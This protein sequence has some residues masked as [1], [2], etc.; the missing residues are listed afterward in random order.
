L[1]DLD[2][3]ATNDNDRGLDPPKIAVEFDTRADNTAGDPP[4]DYC[5][6][7]I[8]ANTDTR[9]D[10]LSGDEDAVQYVF[11]GRENFLNIP[12]R[13][14]PPPP[15]P[16]DISN[17]L[18]DDN[19]HDADGEEPTEEWRFGT[20]GPV[21]IWR[22]GIGPDGTI[23]ISDQ[24]D[25]LYALNEDGSTKWTFNL[26]DG[27]DYMPGVDPVTGTIYSDI[28]G[29]S[30]VSI[31]PDGTENWRFLI[32]PGSDVESTP[33]VGADSV[34]YFG[35]KQAQALIALNP[36]GTEKW[37]FPV[38]DEVNNVPALSPDGLTKV[39]FVSNDNF[40]YA[41]NTV[42][43]LA[44]PTG[45][46]GLKPLQGE[47]RFPIPTES[48]EIQSSPTVKQSDGTIYVGADDNYLYAL[49][50]VARQ[51]DPTGV[52]GVNVAQGEWRF[53]TNGEIESSA[54]LDD[55]G[56]IY[57]GSDD[58]NLWAVNPD[59]TEKWRFATGG[60][61]ESSPIVDLDGTI[62]VGSGDNRVYAINPDGSQKWFFVTGGEVPS[63]PVL[64]QAGFIH[65]GSNDTNFYTIS[66]FGNPRNFRDKLLTSSELGPGLDIEDANDWLN[67]DSFDQKPWAVR[68][69]V[70]RSVVGRLNAAGETVFDYD[71]S[72]WI[73]QCQQLDCS[74]INGTFFSD[75][76]IDYEKAPAMI[77]LPMI[78][79]FSLS[80]AEQL[81]F[82]RFFFGFTGATAAGQTQ[83]ATISQFNLSF[84]RPGDPEVDVAAGD[85]LNWPP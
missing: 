50:E 71:L 49:K 77:N 70:D 16:L 41:L 66:Q 69:E 10:P 56:T 18:Y 4:P 54:A 61:V 80:A 31:D 45:V 43:R 33:T 12:C 67:G 47:W 3:L 74:D 60:A 46:G 22:P 11:W 36:N 55:D 58:A 14:L 1:N 65:I 78:Q 82:E 44:D 20:G 23:Y 15:P 7:A 30:L 72:L 62:Y 52:G 37:R 28:F 59:G 21:S 19:R 8:T 6:D 17:P 68:L 34:I 73:R 51:A 26:S 9:N 29:S 24:V 76:R 48:N 85:D 32:V 57:I 35:T 64:G 81:E 13:G 79:Q 83:D 42:A 75:T 38:G 2:F 25:T 84:I 40:L 27:N 63:S 53:L 39:Y 5:A